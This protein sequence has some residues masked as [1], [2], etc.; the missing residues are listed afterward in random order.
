METERFERGYLEMQLSQCEKK[1]AKLDDDYREAMNENNYLK[2][3][4]QTLDEDEE[5]IK[6]SQIDPATKHLRRQISEKEDE[7][8][9]LTIIYN[10]AKDDIEI[11]NEKL[12]YAESQVTT[13]NTKLFDSFNEVE[14]F[15]SQ[16]DEREK[17]LSYVNNNN[18]ELSEM[19]KE[20]Q[21]NSKKLDFDSSASY[22]MLNSTTSDLNSSGKFQT[23]HTRV[24]IN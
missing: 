14:S 3:Q 19:L 12:Q 6:N 4:I 21:S 8:M 18:R 7:L 9:K 23:D 24:Q 10:E 2:K 16:L 15:K 13:L 11:L 17:M 20:L 22:E 5:S 1:L